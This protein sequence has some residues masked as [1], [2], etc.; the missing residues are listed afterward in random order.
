MMPFALPPQLTQWA[1]RWPALAKLNQKPAV[2]SAFG[3]D[4]GST[5]VKGVL[6]T[7]GPSGMRLERFALAPLPPGAGKPEQV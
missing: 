3:L 7:R 6:L 4:I 5:C 2:S 1:T